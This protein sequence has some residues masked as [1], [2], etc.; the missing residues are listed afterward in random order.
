MRY[1][2][3][4]DPIAHSKSPAIHNAAFAALG[5][6]SSYTAIRVPIGEFSRVVAAMRSGDLN[7][8]NV[9]MPLKEEAYQAVDDHDPAAARAGAVNTVTTSD[10]GLHGCNTDVDGIRFAMQS[11]EASNEAPV[12]ILGAGGAARAAAIAVGDH[13]VVMSARRQEAARA[14]LARSGLVGEIVEWGEPIPGATVVNA[15]PIGMH[16]GELPRPV[17]ERASAFVDMAYG[18][19]PT[20]AVRTAESLGIPTADGLD[21][22][23]GQAAAAFALF[24]GMTPPLD[25]MQAAAREI[26]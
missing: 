16:D 4:G 6:D 11:I 24:T 2:V 12:L 17:L 1:A 9:T 21:M 26:R 19:A 25:I 22:L 13:R 14:A 18:E 20:F 8:V 3:V 10:Q 5:I 7:G 15:T 23:V